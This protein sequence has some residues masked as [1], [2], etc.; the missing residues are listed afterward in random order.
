M[1][2]E[3]EGVSC[4]A[5]PEEAMKVGPCPN[6]TSFKQWLRKTPQQPE[7]LQQPSF[8]RLLTELDLKPRMATTERLLE[9][10]ALPLLCWLRMQCDAQVPI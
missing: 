8:L 5:I 7:K 4:S 6:K 3:E 10:P 1:V 2:A 9:S